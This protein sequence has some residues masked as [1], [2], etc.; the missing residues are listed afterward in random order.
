MAYIVTDLGEEFTFET[1]YQGSS[2]SLDVG[3]YNDGTD[4]I[5]DSNDLSDITTEPGN[6]NYARQSDTF[7]PS[8]LSGDWGVDNDNKLTFDFSDQ[9]TSET[10][11]SWFLVANFQ[12]DDT[13]DGS[14]NDHLIATGGLSQS[15]DIGS[16]D[17]LEISAG[18]VGYKIT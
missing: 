11:D 12:A 6:S 4:S 8:D 18:G 9:S 5:S 10:V 13:G 2:V 17:T 1:D 3:L 14:A 15:R 7:N 16:I